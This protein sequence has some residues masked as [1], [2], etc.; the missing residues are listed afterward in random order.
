MQFNVRVRCVAGAVG[1]QICDAPRVSFD[2]Q[3]N[4]QPNPASGKLQQP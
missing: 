2:D 3:L 4:R 1:D